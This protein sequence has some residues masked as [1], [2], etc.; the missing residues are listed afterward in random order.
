MQFGGFE[1]WNVMSGYNSRLWNKIFSQTKD[2]ELDLQYF[3]VHW[4]KLKHTLFEYNKL[5]DHKKIN[6]HVT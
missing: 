4:F 1:V 3:V 2:I 5:L 6:H